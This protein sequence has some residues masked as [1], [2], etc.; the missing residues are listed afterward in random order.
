MVLALKTY[1]ILAIFA[2]SILFGAASCNRTTAKKTTSTASKTVVKPAPTPKP[3]PKEENTR[4][5]LV[6][7]R[8]TDELEAVLKRAKA[9]NKLVFVDFY[10]SWC[11]PCKIMEQG[12]FVDYE[13]AEFM[14]KNFLNV[15]VNAEDGIGKTHK[16]NFIVFAYPTLLFLNGDGTELMRKE[17]SCSIEELKKM[18]RTALWKQKNPQN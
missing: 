10:T 7:F 2:A 18:G 13:L 16:Q 9:E 4:P 15:R 3:A 17:G 11:L 8:K 12:A 5:M 14:N 6:D 1:Q